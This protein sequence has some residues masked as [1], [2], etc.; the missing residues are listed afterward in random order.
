VSDLI[1]LLE[2]TDVISRPAPLLHLLISIV[3]AAL[4]KSEASES[5]SNKISMPVSDPQQTYINKTRKKKERQRKGMVV[6]KKKTTQGDRGNKHE[7]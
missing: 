3:R 2:S 4:D 7:R 6:R 1:K 5:L